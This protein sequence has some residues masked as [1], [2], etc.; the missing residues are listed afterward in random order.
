[1]IPLQ[2]YSYLM[3]KYLFK[4]NESISPYKELYINVHLIFT[5]NSS[6][7]EADQQ[8]CIF[9]YF[10]RAVQWNSTQKIWKETLAHTIILMN[11]R[12][13]MLSKCSQIEKD[14]IPHYS[15]YISV[16]IIQIHL[17]CHQAD[18]FFWDVGISMIG[19]VY[20]KKSWGDA[21]DCWYVYYLDCGDDFMVE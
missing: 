15:I 7:V 5:W 17:Q 2:Y 3:D 14:Y 9:I 21:L 19:R 1:M 12:I 11:L 16:R 18:K 6:K 4:R 10:G 8:V 20:F 13:T